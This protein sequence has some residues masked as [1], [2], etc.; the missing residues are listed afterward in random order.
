MLRVDP[1]NGI[2]RLKEPTPYEPL[3]PIS[4]K[5]RL[6]V[7]DPTPAVVF[8]PMPL[9]RI[10]VVREPVEPVEEDPDPMRG[11]PSPSDPNPAEELREPPAKG[12]ARAKIPELIEEVG[13]I[14]VRGIKIVRDPL[15]LSVPGII[16]PGP[17]DP[18]VRS[19]RGPAVCEVGPTPN[20][21]IPTLDIPVAMLLPE[22][23][24]VSWI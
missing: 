10:R 2:T 17:G 19:P 24:P 18:N 3:I 22:P 1:A 20:S 6:I 12:R 9:S 13:P 7:A 8:T 21:D 16:I 4:E 14:P 11:M 15:A 5:R 23:R